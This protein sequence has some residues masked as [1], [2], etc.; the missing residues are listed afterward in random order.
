MGSVDSVGFVRAIGSAKYLDSAG[1]LDSV[2]GM[3][4][5]Y[6]LCTLFFDFLSFSFIF[7]ELQ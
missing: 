7:F 4:Q 1:H 5:R 2:G 6:I 3:W